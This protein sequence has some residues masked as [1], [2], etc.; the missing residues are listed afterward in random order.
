[1]LYSKIVNVILSKFGF[2]STNTNAKKWNN[3]NA[4]KIITGMDDCEGAHI[5]GWNP[6]CTLENMLILW[7]III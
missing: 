5:F 6:E 1:M 7:F 3:T 2:D 4:S